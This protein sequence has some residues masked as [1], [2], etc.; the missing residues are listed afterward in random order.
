VPLRYA[1]TKESGQGEN[2][3]VD[4]CQWNPVNGTIEH[5][6]VEEMNALMTEGLKIADSRL[7]EMN[8]RML[9]AYGLEKYFTPKEWNRV[10]SILDILSGRQ[11]PYQ[12]VSRWESE[13]E[14]TRELENGRLEAQKV[15]MNGFDI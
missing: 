2:L 10:I 12:V 1:I 9:S 4:V 7:L 11:T 15:K 5:T 6:T 3:V 8:T 14:E 13:I